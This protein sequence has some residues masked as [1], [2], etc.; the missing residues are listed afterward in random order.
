[1][2]LLLV[3]S[4]G[5]SAAAQAHGPRHPSAFIEKVPPSTAQCRKTEAGIA[6]TPG[7][8][9]T[10]VPR[11]ICRDPAETAVRSTAAQCLMAYGPHGT[12]FHK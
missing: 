3:I 9:S 10:V 12:L 1:M 7:P 6:L 11:V 2:R 8:R 4:V 5:L